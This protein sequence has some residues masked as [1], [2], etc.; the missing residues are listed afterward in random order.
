MELPER[1]G[2]YMDRK[3]LVVHNGL[4]YR[5]IYADLYSDFGYGG[6]LVVGALL[7]AWSARTYTR[8]ARHPRTFLIYLIIIPGTVFFPSRTGTSR[9]PTCCRSVCC[10]FSGCTGL[11]RSSTRSS[12]TTRRKSPMRSRWPLWPKH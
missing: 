9:S 10:C 11:V 5:T 8:A 1:A 2:E 3:G 6:S 12:R 7:F 4:T